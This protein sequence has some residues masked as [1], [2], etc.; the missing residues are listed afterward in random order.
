MKRFAV[1]V[2]GTFT[3]VIYSDDE[4]GEFRLEKV[5]STPTAPSEAVV[6]SIGRTGVDPSHV[7][8]FVHGTTTALNSLLQRKVSKTGLITTRGFRDILEIGRCNRPDSQQ[9][10]LFWKRPEPFVPRYLRREVTER[11]SWDGKVVTELD[12]KGV[13]DIVKS[14]KDLG[15]RS[16]AV[17]L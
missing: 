13:E 17:S 2:G 1:D 8:L 7:P 9:Y 11:M 14:F 15:V 5:R 4:T 10:N 6:E 3:D 12:Q 16:I